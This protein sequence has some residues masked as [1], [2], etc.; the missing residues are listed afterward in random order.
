MNVVLVGFM[1][2]GKTVVAKRLAEKLNMRYISLDE[3][4]VEREGKSINEIFEEDGETYFRK[5]EKEVT[6][7]VSE[8]KEV[9]ID[10]GG[11][12]V[13]DNENISNLK[14][15]GIMVCLTASPKVI[16]ERTKQDDSRPL[17]NVEN[18]KNK[19]K[20]L[21]EK[22]EPFYAN[23]DYTIDTSK[24]TINEVA[25]KVISIMKKAKDSF[26]G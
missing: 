23:A 14:K 22:R 6:K 1:G 20:E 7:E 19:I 18:P 12:V 3:E 17:L 5:V 13:K 21:L 2:T 26:K 24:L 4:I 15:R 16:Y 11:G 25:K 9:V 8:L 10:A